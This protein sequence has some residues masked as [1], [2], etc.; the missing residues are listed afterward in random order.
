MAV[1]SVLGRRV[2]CLVSDVCHC[3]TVFS[4]IHGSRLHPQQVAVVR[5]RA[6]GAVDPLDVESWWSPAH[7]GD[8]RGENDP[9]GS[10]CGEEA[11]VSRLAPPSHTRECLEPPIDEPR[12]S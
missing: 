4:F 5:S 10:A 1:T 12:G 8:E 11:R 7:A 6:E 9:V 3:G 2:L